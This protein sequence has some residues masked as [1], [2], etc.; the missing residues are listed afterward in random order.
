M[1][2]HQLQRVIRMFTVIRCIVIALTDFQE[3]S[4]AVG[5]CLLLDADL[6]LSEC[7]A[8]HL[9]CNI[10]IHEY[11]QQRYSISSHRWQTSKEFQID[12]DP[13]PSC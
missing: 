9:F 6:L 4:S 7:E 10:I 1:D 11:K 12:L 8:F 13:Y 5:E 3:P 2:K